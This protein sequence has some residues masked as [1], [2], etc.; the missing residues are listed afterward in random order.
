MNNKTIDLRD[1][2][3]RGLQLLLVVDA[4]CKKNNI[5][6][7]LEGGTLLGAVR[8]KGFIPWD[9][10]VDVT[11]LREDYD[12]FIKLAGKSF[13]E[14][15]FVQTNDSDTDYPFGFAKII[16][17]KSKFM[18]NR[19]KFRTGFCIDVVPID[20]AHDNKLVHNINIFM[21][22]VIQGLTKAKIALDMYNYRGVIIK[23]SVMIAAL[24]GKV[25]TTKFL[26]S[27]Q[28]MIA[29]A[30]NHRETKNK[31]IYCYP[32]DYLD[33][34]FPSTV[35]KSIEMM[36]FEGYIFPAPTGWD[37]ILTILYD[38]YMQLP[39]VEKRLPL[40]GFTSVLFEDD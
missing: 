38:D 10:D 32:F 14:Q 8:H 18:N 3:N 31:C 36:E 24:A 6:Y 1:I 9:D 17:L 25:F 20:N 7:Y 37:Q 22:K 40:H 13:P 26:M 29:T 2:Q 27:I 21:I 28:K 11:M 35:Y 12:Q 4:F 16:D 34:L 19:N 15:Y 39:P 33:R 30:S 5:S 23:A